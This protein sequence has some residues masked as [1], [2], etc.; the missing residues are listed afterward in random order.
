M[1]FKTFAFL[2]VFSSLHQLVTMLGRVTTDLRGFVSFYFIV[3]WILSL[4]FDTLGLSN[5][6]LEEVE[7]EG[8]DRLDKGAEYAGVEYRNLPLWFS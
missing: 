6:P 7:G 2:R 5:L 4:I 8:F 3:L 1:L